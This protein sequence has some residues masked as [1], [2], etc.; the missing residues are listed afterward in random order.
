VRR[1]TLT[2]RQPLSAHGRYGW[3]ATYFEREYPELAARPY[4]LPRPLFDCLMP[5]G[6]N[7]KGWQSNQEAMDA[8]SRACVVF[9]T[10]YSRAG[11]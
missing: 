11:W 5:A 9:G 8:L 3:D 6:K 2:D 4:N 10:H 7:A 1:V